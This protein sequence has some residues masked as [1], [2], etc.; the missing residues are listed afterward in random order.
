[1]DPADAGARCTS[2]G[3]QYPVTDNVLRCVGQEHYSGSFGYQWNRFARTQLDSANGRARSRETFEQKTGWRLADLQGQVVLDAGCG[4]GRFAEVALDAG[5]RVCALDLSAAV[6]AAAENLGRREAIRFFQGD[7]LNPPFTDESFDRIYSIGVLHH[8]PDTRAA[9]LRLVRLLRPGGHIAVWV[10]SDRLRRT[11]AGAEV[12]RKVT[13]RLPKP[14]LLQLTR[15]AIPL[16]YLHRIPV[17][18][19]LTRAALPISMEGDR[20]WRWLDT[21][22]WYS[23]TYQW[24]HTPEEVGAWFDEAGLQ[25]V[26]R[27]S[28]PV[29]FNGVRPS[30]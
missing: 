8:T 13:P 25:N 24:K 17:V 28:I 23:P 15:A 2:C 21:F 26:R 4:M 27:L 11:L 12:L 5:A 29:S 30:K 19:R 10:Y 16:Y 14:L 6:T 9:F 7:I 18:G 1:M 22:D 3:A 20:E